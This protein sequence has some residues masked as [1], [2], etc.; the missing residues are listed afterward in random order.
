[1]FLGVYS[2]GVELSEP[3]APQHIAQKPPKQMHS[4]SVPYTHT[5][6][7]REETPRVSEEE[8][9]SAKACTSITNALQGWAPCVRYE[10][11]IGVAVMVVETGKP[12]IKVTDPAAGVA[13][14]AVF[15]DLF[16]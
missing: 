7:K 11:P 6:K 5:R 1:M 16:L 15:V 3:E 8:A 12:N 4:S 10:R 9:G 2:G 13:K 14:V